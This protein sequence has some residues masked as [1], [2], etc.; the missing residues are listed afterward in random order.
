MCIGEVAHRS[1]VPIKT[2]RYYEEIGVL[3]EPRRS[4]SRDR[5]YESDAVE[6]LGIIRASQAFGLSLGEI[7]EVVYLD[8]GDVPCAHVLDLVRRRSREI[9]ER[10]A[11]LQQ[12]TDGSTRRT[13][14]I[15]A[16]RLQALSS[17][18]AF[19]LRSGVGDGRQELAGRLHRETRPIQPSQVPVSRHEHVDIGRL[20]E[21]DE[22]VVVWV[23]SD[24]LCRGWRV[25]HD[26]G[27]LAHHHDEPMDVVIAQVPSELRPRE[28]RLQLVQQ[29]RRGD[30]PVPARS[31]GNQ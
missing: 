3:P 28:H 12:G 26:F 5:D 23:R 25:V 30:K 27:Q 19:R 6:R 18:G 7:R 29:H 2:I 22:E 11:E 24:R 1:G 13:V 20:R 31:C 8:R 4:A 16:N 10:I 9:G 17:K 14:E 21:H 15:V